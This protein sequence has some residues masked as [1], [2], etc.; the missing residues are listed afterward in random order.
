MTIDE[1]LAK[2]EGITRRLE[3]DD[4]PLEEALVLFEQGIELATAAKTQLDEAR[5]RIQKVVEKAKESFDLQEFDL[6]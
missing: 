1:T 3:A 4:V 6:S 5:L 2:L